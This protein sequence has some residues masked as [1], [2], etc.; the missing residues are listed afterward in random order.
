[1]DVWIAG[2]EEVLIELSIQ[3]D[4]SRSITT[5]KLPSVTEPDM[6]IMH[7]EREALK[8]YRGHVKKLNSKLKDKSADDK[9]LCSCNL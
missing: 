2:L 6:R 9:I 4:V 7:N 5:A 8:L 3:V 1:M